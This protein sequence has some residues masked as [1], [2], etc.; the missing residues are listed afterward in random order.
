MPTK[1]ASCRSSTVNHFYSAVIIVQCILTVSPWWGT[2][3][4]GWGSRSLST[5]RLMSHTSLL[6]PPPSPPPLSF[7]RY[8]HSRW[9]VYYGLDST[10]QRV[11][12]SITSCLKIFDLTYDIT[13]RGGTSDKTLE[14]FV[15][16][17]KFTPSYMWLICRGDSGIDVLY[18][19][20]SITLHGLHSSQPCLIHA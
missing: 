16:A 19:D 18:S 5:H 17:H 1:A 11:K 10:S 15:E 2:A 20:L 8:C 4:A 7:T 14:L 13:V 6:S 3:A 9:P 12:N